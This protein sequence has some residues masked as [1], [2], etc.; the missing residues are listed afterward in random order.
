[1]VRLIRIASTVD[2]PR[3]NAHQ[4]LPPLSPSTDSNTTCLWKACIIE[5]CAAAITITGFA[6]S[7]LQA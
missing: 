4:P 1:M 6:Q 2:W 3:L 7:L 5:I